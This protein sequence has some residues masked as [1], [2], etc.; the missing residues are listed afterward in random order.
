MGN[1]RTV[2]IQGT[3]DAA[4]VPALR[5][6][7]RWGESMEGFHCLTDT[8]GVMGL[9]GWAAETIDAQ[10]NLAERGYSVQQVADTLATL[11]KVAPSLRVK[12]HC[13]GDYED[14]KV[15]ATITLA[16]GLVVVGPPEKA[17]LDEAS[18]AEIAGRFLLAIQRARE[19]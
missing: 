9:N 13:G 8:G 18:D 16:D 12:V 2:H 15:V 6:A 19:L 14:T 5:A 10:G 11:S 7:I 3:C 17:D 4:E 1:W